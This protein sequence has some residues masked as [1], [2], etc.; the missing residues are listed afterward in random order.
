MWET[1]P[2]PVLD[3]DRSMPIGDRIRRPLLGVSG[4]GDD[5]DTPK[6][7]AGFSSHVI[8][9]YDME[10]DCGVISD[11]HRMPRIRDADPDVIRLKSDVDGPAAPA[12]GTIRPG[13]DYRHGGG[14]VN[15]RRAGEKRN[16]P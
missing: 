8:P 13:A 1:P 6:L 12:A 10:S 11:V 7:S 3:A 4:A 5:F 15:P 14:T 2:P 9:W 16:R